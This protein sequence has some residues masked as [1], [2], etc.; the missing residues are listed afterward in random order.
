MN[1][2]KFLK[3]EKG[4]SMMLLLFMIPLFVTMAIVVLSVGNV[5]FAESHA[6]SL[7]ERSVS[8][9]VDETQQNNSVRDLVFTVPQET[10]LGIIKQRLTDAGFV[11]ELGGYRYGE[12]YTITGLTGT[13]NGDVLTIQADLN[14]TMPWRIADGYNYVHIPMTLQAHIL[15]MN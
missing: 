9:A 11:A 4:D 2:K 8:I 3:E 7:M 12:V 14:V 1:M 5:Y 13:V 10:A 15:F 6:R